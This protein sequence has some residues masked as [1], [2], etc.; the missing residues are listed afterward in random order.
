MFDR[1]ALVGAVVEKNVSQGC[2]L[3]PFSAECQ[4]SD[5]SGFAQCMCLGKEAAAC[6]GEMGGQR[7]M[8]RGHSRLIAG[9]LLCVNLLLLEC[10]FFVVLR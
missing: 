5:I 10:V 8:D 7:G 1:I 4:S 2:F 9:W 6:R 3:F